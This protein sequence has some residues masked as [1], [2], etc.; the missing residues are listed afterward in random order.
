MQ[1]LKR[2]EKSV[3]E[4]AKKLERSNELQVRRNIICIFFE[5]YDRSETV[6]EKKKEIVN[7][8]LSLFLFFFFFIISG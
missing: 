3:A 5:D 2:K 4:F 8:Y 1:K 6:R 7:F